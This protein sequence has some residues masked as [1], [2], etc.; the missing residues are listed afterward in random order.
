M[1]KKSEDKSPLIQL[2][3]F[4]KNCSEVGDVFQDVLGLFV[5]VLANDSH[6]V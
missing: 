3:S 1:I 2:N 6:D 4:E 5:R